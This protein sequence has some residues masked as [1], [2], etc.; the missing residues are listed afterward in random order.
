MKKIISAILVFTIIAACGVVV[1]AKPTGMYVNNVYV[2]REF[3]TIGRFDMLPILDIAGELGF[4]CSRNENEFKLYNDKKTYHFTV[5][6]ASVFDQNGKW[7]G[8]DVVPTIINGRI[9]IPNN[10]L[11]NNME[12]SYTWDSITSTLFINSDYTYKWLINTS[13]YRAEKNKQKEAAAKK[14]KEAKEAEKRNKNKAA[15]SK[16]YVGQRV[17]QNLV[18]KYTKY[19]IVKAIDYNSGKIQVYWEKT[20]DNYGNLYN[21]ILLGTTGTYWLDPTSIYN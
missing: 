16:F 21:N 14:E 2:T 17:Y 3:A 13:E 7:Y 19:G 1:S 11:I 6:K 18:F 15:L 10:F 9:M 8:L 4:S 20:L 12:V 5:G